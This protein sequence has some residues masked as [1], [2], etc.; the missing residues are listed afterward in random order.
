MRVD[1]WIAGAAAALGMIVLAN[2]F[3]GRGG[4]APNTVP[5]TLPGAMPV[6]DAAKYPGIQAAI[7]G[8]RAV[9]RVARGSCGGSGWR[10]SG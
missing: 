7:D 10:I 4:A 1:R 9:T 8:I 5:A 3:A 2:G 6:I